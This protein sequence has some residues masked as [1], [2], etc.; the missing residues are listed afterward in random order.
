MAMVIQGTKSVEFGE[1]HLE[2]GAGQ[3]L[4]TSIDV[5]VHFQDREREQSTSSPGRRPGGRDQDRLEIMAELGISCGTTAGV[6]KPMASTNRAVAF[7][8][9]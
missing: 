9:K 4:L 5:P 1:A 7:G 2:Y 6:G 8:E 3:Y